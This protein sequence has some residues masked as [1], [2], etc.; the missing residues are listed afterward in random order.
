MKKSEVRVT[1]ENVQFL[2]PRQAAEARGAA[3]AAAGAAE[4]G[5]AV[6]T[7]AEAEGTIFEEKP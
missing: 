7:Q 4:D 1:A 2:G 6:T 3:D 5:E